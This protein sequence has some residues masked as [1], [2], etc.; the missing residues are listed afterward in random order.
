MNKAWDHITPRTCVFNFLPSQ[1][2]VK[3][4]IPFAIS[5]SRA[6]R[7]VNVFLI[8]S[9]QEAGNGRNPPSNGWLDEA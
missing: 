6:K 9:L 7:A 1:Q 5:V 3:R 2:K 8:K 4:K